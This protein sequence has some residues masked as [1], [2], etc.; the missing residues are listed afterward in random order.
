MVGGVPRRLRLHPVVGSAVAT[1]IAAIAVLVIARVTGADAVGRAFDNIE[2]VW[3]ALIAGAELITYPAYVIAYRSIAGLHGHAPLAL[4]MVARVVVAG[5]GPFSIWG[6]FGLDRQAL[7]ALHEDERS[8]RVRVIALGVLEWVVLAPIAWVTA[9]VFLITDAN[10]MPSLLWPWAIG[11]PVG[12]GFAFWASSPRRIER[13]RRLGGRRREWAGGVLEGVGIMRSMIARPLTWA[14]AWLGTALY[15]VADMAAFYGALRAFGLDPGVGKVIIAYA[16]GYAA[17]R[18]SL[19]LGG[20]G[21][22]EFLMTYAL[23]WVRMP[24]APALAAVVAYRAFNLLLAAAPALLARHQ[25]EPLLARRRAATSPSGRP[26]SPAA[27][28]R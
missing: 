13:M 25:L 15:W 2:P 11:V 4:P 22:T 16:T 24:L 7:D 23:Y 20:A 6:G 9:V 19:P 28:P 3:I 21:I 1:G 8:A 5:F 26:T 17:T 14:P 12:L 27:P 10:V 18:R